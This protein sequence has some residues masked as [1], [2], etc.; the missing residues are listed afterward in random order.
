MVI[1]SDNDAKVHVQNRLCSEE[2]PFLT[3]PSTRLRNQRSKNSE[4]ELVGSHLSIVKHSDDD[5]DDDEFSLV[6]MP[7]Y[8]RFYQQNQLAWTPLITPKFVI[9]LFL[10]CS[11]LFVP[12]GIILYFT[13][14][15]IYEFKYDY[16]DCIDLQSTKNLTCHSQL[17]KN[18]KYKCTCRVFFQ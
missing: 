9:N 1:E 17:A 6:N 8:S 14:N 13:S 12:I 16:T 4:L 7:K 10:I 18:Y 15:N 5:D 2:K 3:K 11:L